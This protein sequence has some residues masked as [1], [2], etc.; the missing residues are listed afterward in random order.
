MGQIKTA[1]HRPA[2]ESSSERISDQLLDEGR[3]QIA[4]HRL[5]IES[6]SERI[7][8]QLLDEGRKQI[9]GHRLA[10]ESVGDQPLATDELQRRRCRRRAC[11]CV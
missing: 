6:G 11:V 4:G 5:A 7:S 1:G 8:D 2:I 3:K 10:V 9:A